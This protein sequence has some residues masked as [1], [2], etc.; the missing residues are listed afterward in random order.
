MPNMYS[1]KA[2][3]GSSLRSAS[4]P[5]DGCCDASGIELAGC[6]EFARLQVGTIGG[7]Q[8]LEQ[9]QRVGIGFLFDVGEAQ[10][11]HQRP[12]LR[13]D[14]ESAPVNRNGLIGTA[15]SR[16]HHAEIPQGADVIWRGFEHLLE[17]RFGRRVIC[18]K[19][20]PR[21]PSGIPGVRHRRRTTGRTH[22]AGTTVRA[23]IL[24]M[25]VR[26]ERMVGA[27]DRRPLTRRKS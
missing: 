14:A 20:E 26:G 4:R 1:T 7:D 18:R 21:R 24:I 23:Y 3:L 22:L 15:G 9:R 13:G 12:V 8:F 2:G 17:A 11:E 27:G 16:V 10:I 5:L 19:I 6:Q 25:A